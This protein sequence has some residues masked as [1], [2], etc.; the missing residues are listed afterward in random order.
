MVLSGMGIVLLLLF[1]SMFQ[2]GAI[3]FQLA[4]MAQGWDTQQ[5]AK[6]CFSGAIIYAV[7][8][9]ISVLYRIYARKEA[10]KLKV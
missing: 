3:S 2:N 1:G 8:L 5:K 7:T 9:V 10:A 6:A 4:S